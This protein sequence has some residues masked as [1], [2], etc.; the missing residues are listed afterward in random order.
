MDEQPPHRP[1]A[2]SQTGPTMPQE[3]SFETFVKDALTRIEEKVESTDFDLQVL[4]ERVKGDGSMDHLGYAGELALVKK[5]VDGLE[6]IW[7]KVFLVL[8]IPAGAALIYL[9]DKIIHASK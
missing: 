5:R 8:T 9:G 4:S 7:A 2:R 3:H 1:R 6:S